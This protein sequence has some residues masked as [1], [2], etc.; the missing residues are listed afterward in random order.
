MVIYIVTFG[1][2]FGF[3]S[4]L[5]WEFCSRIINCKFS[6]NVFY[7]ACLITEFYKVSYVSYGSWNTDECHITWD[8]SNYYFWCYNIWY[9]LLLTIYWLT[10]NY[11]GFVL[12]S[13]T[14][15]RRS[16]DLTFDW[17]NMPSLND[18]ARQSR[19]F[20]RSKCRA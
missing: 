12:I 4:Y 18:G 3:S 2:K 13:L 6:Q 17:P 20:T 16:I 19:Q 8:F 5:G 11:F 14:V 15:T 7:S 9:M 1:T 10:Y